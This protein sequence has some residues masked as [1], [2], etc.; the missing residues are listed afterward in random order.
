M[1]TAEN[2]ILKNAEFFKKNMGLSDEEAMA[3]A[4]SLAAE[5]ENSAATIRVAR[6]FL[7]KNF[8]QSERLVIDCAD[9]AEVVKETEKAVR[10]KWTSDH[11][12]F[13]AWVPRSCLVA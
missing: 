10:I 9:S 12:A 2:I 5:L 6:W 8:S 1:K 3:K 7:Q 4:R 13:F 11:G